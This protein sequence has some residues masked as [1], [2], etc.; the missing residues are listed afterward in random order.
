HARQRFGRD[1]ADHRADE[2]AVRELVEAERLRRGRAPQ[3]Q[4]V[5]AARAVADDRPIVRDADDRGRP[6]WNDAD[7]RSPQLEAGV[8]RYLKLLAGP[9]DLP[10]VGLA[11]PVVRLFD[12]I[13][14]ANR[15]P[16][17]AVLV[18]QA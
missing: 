18:L 9:R 11:Q 5:D 4:R 15:L 3:P 10:R 12:L 14:V 17:D 8:Q 7:R 13:A 1:V 16:E 6:I 2:V